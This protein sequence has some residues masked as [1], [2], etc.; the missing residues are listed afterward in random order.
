MPPKAAF[1]PS[2]IMVFM[3]IM[4]EVTTFLHASCERQREARSF[5]CFSTMAATSASIFFAS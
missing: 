4:V 1:N 5:F 3:T 2:P